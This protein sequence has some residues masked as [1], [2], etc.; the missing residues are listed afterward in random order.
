MVGRKAL[1]PQTS[2][3]SDSESAP[4]LWQIALTMDAD[5]PKFE[6]DSFISHRVADHTDEA[7][8][9]LVFRQAHSQ[10]AWVGGWF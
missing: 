1:N 10:G 8:I 7:D 6:G 9:G 5:S 2:V 3:L 4:P